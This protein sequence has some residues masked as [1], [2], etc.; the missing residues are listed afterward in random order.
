MEGAL[1]ALM[2]RI[3]DPAADAYLQ[4]GDGGGDKLPPNPDACPNC[5]SREYVFSSSGE[6]APGERVCASCGAAQPGINCWETRYGRSVP[7]KGSNYKRI[8]HWH[9]RISQFMLHDTS[10]SPDQM[11]AIGRRILDGTF[12][13]VNKDSIRAVL[14]SLDL[15]VYIEKW[16]QIAF[17]VLSLPTPIFSTHLIWRMD[18]IFMS[19]QEPFLAVKPEGRTNFLNYNYVFCRI[20]QLLGVPKYSA[21][22]PLIKSPAKMRDLEATWERM[23]RV[24]HIEFTP[25]I[26]EPP[27]SVPLT[28]PTKLLA[29]LERRCAAASQAGP[30]TERRQTGLLPSDRSTPTAGLKRPPPQ[31]RSDLPAVRF[32]RVGWSKSRPR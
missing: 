8:H 24:M 22:F 25:L 31:S 14:R 3:V 27:L 1:H 16:M 4:L 2:A 29:R 20:F 17:N 28:E 9:E 19:L 18:E 15:Q 7:V 10:I 6:G 5:D 13:H 32:Q 21:F 12:T 30:H 23:C 11:L 26:K